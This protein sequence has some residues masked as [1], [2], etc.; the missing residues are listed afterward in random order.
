MRNSGSRL[1]LFGLAGSCHSGE[2]TE[3][4]AAV[5][6]GVASAAASSS[7]PIGRRH[8]DV[9]DAGVDPLCKTLLAEEKLDESALA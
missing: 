2:L 5:E 4:P 6:A 7:A 1:S 9:A 8:H 3:K